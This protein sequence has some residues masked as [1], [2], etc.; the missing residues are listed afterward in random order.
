MF[1]IMKQNLTSD[2]AMGGNQLDTSNPL[3]A[4]AMVQGKHL[5]PSKEPSQAL[6]NFSCWILGR[7]WGERSG[8]V[9]GA[10]EGLRVVAL[11]P[12]LWKYFNISTTG[13]SQLNISHEQRGLQMPLLMNIL[14]NHPAPT[15]SP[16]TIHS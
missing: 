10:L 14:R 8:T 6:M 12:L 15:S 4:L 9:G 2:T 11:Y 3:L 16:A 13:T 1:I 7:V 5:F